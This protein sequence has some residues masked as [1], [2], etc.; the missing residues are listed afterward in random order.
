MQA[1]FR[2]HIR[3]VIENG[4]LNMFEKLLVR[5]SIS[6]SP[7]DSRNIFNRA[8]HWNNDNDSVLLSIGNFDYTSDSILVTKP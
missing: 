7:N 6:I 1:T 5:H 3:S 8:S 4:S 2:L